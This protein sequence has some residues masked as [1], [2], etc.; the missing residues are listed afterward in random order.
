MEYTDKVTEE[1]ARA[2][3]KLAILKLK[4]ENVFHS[5]PGKLLSQGGLLG[6]GSQGG[7]E[8]AAFNR[9]VEH[10]NLSGNLNSLLN[11]EAGTSPSRITEQNKEVSVTVEKVAPQDPETLKNSSKTPEVKKTKEQSSLPT[12]NQETH[13]NGPPQP[14][15]SPAAPIVQ[16]AA[17]T[18]DETVWA[19]QVEAARIRIHADSQELAEELGSLPG[20]PGKAAITTIEKM[21]E[22]IDK[23]LGGFDQLVAQYALAVPAGCR[24]QILTQ[25]AAHRLQLGQ[26]LREIKRKLRGFSYA[27]Q[28][29]S[30][31]PSERP[32]S[33]IEKIK[34]PTYSGQLEAWPDFLK[35]WS[36]ITAPE[37]MTD[38]V[39]LLCLRQHI[40]QEARDLLDGVQDMETAWSRLKRKYGDRDLIILH[41]TKRLNS[42]NLSVQ[43]YEQVEKLALECE[44][45]VTLLKYFNAESLLLNDFELVARLS[46]KLPASLLLSWDVSCSER[47]GDSPASCSS[48]PTT[49]A[50]RSASCSASPARRPRPAP[51]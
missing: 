32:R 33:F 35:A 16:E 10:L 3:E 14:R 49:A 50:R 47:G 6:R 24:D 34:L 2:E 23:D 17:V 29:K 28:Q 12:G 41:V 46:S 44:R 18:P 21:A 20:Q 1:T 51:C 38:A 27:V 9:D 7:F 25:G 5:P 40:P 42:I 15:F 4:T 48:I 36:D 37:R 30:Q 43:S 26:E 45:A 8:E 39:E 22:N 11:N 19:G 31:D 13:L